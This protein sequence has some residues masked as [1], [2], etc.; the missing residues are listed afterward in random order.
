MLG[1]NRF[2]AAADRDQAGSF[3]DAFSR[4]STAKPCRFSPATCYVRRACTTAICSW[5][6]MAFSKLTSRRK[7]R[8]R[9]F[10]FLNRNPDWR[11]RLSTGY[12][13]E[14]DGK[15]D[16]ELLRSVM[17]DDD[18]L[19]RLESDRPA[20]ASRFLAS[21]GTG[22]RREDQLQ[23][24][25]LEGGPHTRKAPGSRYWSAEP[26]ICSSARRH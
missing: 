26:R 9:S 23:S 7:T 6:S 14:R 25:D 12:R 15:G 1:R 18:V 16:V 21:F 24:P 22:R 3:V 17:I 11:D 19:E 2:V 10:K 20:I 4:H 5:S 8:R 13:G